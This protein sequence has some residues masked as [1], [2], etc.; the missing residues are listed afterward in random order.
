MYRSCRCLTPLKNFIIIWRNTLMKNYP[1]LRYDTAKYTQS[2]KET[3]KKKET[4]NLTE[5]LGESLSSRFMSERGFS[6]ILDLADPQNNDKKTE[7]SSP[8]LPSEQ[9]IR[10]NTYNYFKNNYDPYKNTNLFSGFDRIDNDAIKRGSE[11]AGQIIANNISSGKL[12]DIYS[13]PYLSDGLTMFYAASEKG[14]HEIADRARKMAY[15]K[16]E[17]KSLSYDELIKRMRSETTSGSVDTKK[18]DEE[19]DSALETAETVLDLIS[20]IPGVDTISNIAQIPVHLLQKDY[21]GVLLDIA[22]AVPL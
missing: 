8:F 9:E 5:A 16:E 18:K 21:V 15:T 19:F 14:E 2:G 13:Y 3:N 1:N 4:E 17:P 11:T 7:K 12:Y 20:L 6:G 10:N 22:G